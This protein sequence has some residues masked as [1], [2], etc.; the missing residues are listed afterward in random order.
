MDGERFDRFAR[1]WASGLSRRGLLRGLAAGVAGVAVGATR[2]RA[3]AQTSGLAQGAA[4]TSSA[5]CSQIGGTT[6][7]AD[8]GIAADG[9]LNCC[10][11]EGGSCV[12]GPGCCGALNCVG[13]VCTSGAAT[14]TL[15]PGAICTAASQC[16]QA[17]GPVACANNGLAVDG[18]LNCC[19]YAGGACASDPGCCANL[20][21]LG[22]VCQ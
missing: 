6:V 15:P 5:Q 16:S 20:L 2:G 12:S 11:N 4:C 9:A 13:F 18:G 8:N 1:A 7:C 10:R 22:G 3:S 14:G 17:G 19:R 21:C